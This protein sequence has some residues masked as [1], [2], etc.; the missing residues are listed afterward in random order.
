M[1]EYTKYMA[2]GF[3]LTGHD[4]LEPNAS[5]S[6]ERIEAMRELHDAGFKTWASIEPVIDFD[7]SKEMIY[8]S[9]GFCNLYKVGLESGK[10]YS[11]KELND[12]INFVCSGKSLPTQYKIYFKDG[13]LKQAGISRS[14][15]PD[16]CVDKDYNLFK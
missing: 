7:S 16:N 11:K 2:P 10:K 13:L 1:R 6:A 15:L 14:E 9:A 5:T 8:E 3:T 4:E 12:F